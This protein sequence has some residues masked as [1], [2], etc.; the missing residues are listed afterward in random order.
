MDKHSSSPAN[1]T[2]GDNYYDMG[3]SPVSEA[4]PQLKAHGIDVQAFTITGNEDY[5]QEIHGTLSEN[6]Y[7]NSPGVIGRAR[8]TY[9]HLHG[10]I[11]SSDESS[12]EMN[13]YSHIA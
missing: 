9:D 3:G 11:K 4:H 5:S 12:V 8:E 13:T 6:I 10:P 7:Q 1:P 2:H